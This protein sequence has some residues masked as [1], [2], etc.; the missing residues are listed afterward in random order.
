A[1]LTLFTITTVFLAA[2]L[3]VLRSLASLAAT[4]R[5][6]GAGDLSARAI[7]PSGRGE[8]AALAR[9]FNGM[10]AALARRDR[11]AA[12]SQ[13]R[14]RLLAK[15]LNAAREAEAVRISRE[16]HDEIGQMLTSLKIDL[17]HLRSRL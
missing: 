3:A 11:E 5:R 10:A 17:H 2:D 14:L 1:V 16:L 9:A 6:L 8:L 7:E 13:E 15:N 12:E 4:A